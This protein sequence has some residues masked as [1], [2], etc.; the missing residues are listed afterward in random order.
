MIY[1]FCSCYDKQAQYNYNS[2]SKHKTMFGVVAI[3]KIGNND[4]EINK[5]A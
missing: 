4:W 5:I 3:V 1:S 2:L